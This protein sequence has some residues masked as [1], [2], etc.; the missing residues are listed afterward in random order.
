[1][2]VKN[3]IRTV[4]IVGI[5]AWPTVETYRLWAMTQKLQAAQALQRTADQ[6]LAA[7]REKHAQIAKAEPRS[8]TPEK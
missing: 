6:N 8:A 3:W 4:V 1:M 7:A 2:N 5:V